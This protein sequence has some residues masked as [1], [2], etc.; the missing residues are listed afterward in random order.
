M[1]IENGQNLKNFKGLASSWMRDVGQVVI[2]QLDFINK[3]NKAFNSPVP[4]SVSRI[5]ASGKV[6]TNQ[7]EF[8]ELFVSTLTA[9]PDVANKIYLGTKTTSDPQ[10]ATEEARESREFILQNPV[11]VALFGFGLKSMIPVKGFPKPKGNPQ[12][13]K[14]MDESTKIIE[15]ANEI[16]K[17]NIL[18]E[19]VAPSVAKIADFIRQFNIRTNFKSRY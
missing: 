19:D 3:A 11:S 18:P 16:K 17:G 4:F 2:G 8:A 5:D 12:L 10:Y 14:F 1:L 9:M 13:I 6:Y 15:T 7:E